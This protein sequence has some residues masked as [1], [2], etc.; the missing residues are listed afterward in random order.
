M[1]IFRHSA[2]T[3]ELGA[4]ADVQDGSCETLPVAYVTTE[5]GMFALSFWKP[6]AHELALINAGHPVALGVRAV[7][8]QHPVVFVTTAKDPV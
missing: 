8:R 5:H 4:P 6:D 7:G 3:H 1:E 2:C